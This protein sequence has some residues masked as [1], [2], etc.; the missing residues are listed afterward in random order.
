MKKNLLLAINHCIRTSL[1]SRL[2][3]VFASC[4]LPLCSVTSIQAA[5]E[6]EK[7][8]N[9]PSDSQNLVNRLDEYEEREKL[10]LEKVLDMKRGEAL[11]ILNKKRG[12]V[13]TILKK[14]LKSY[15]KN[16][17]FDQALAIRTEIS[18][19]EA[20]S[21]PTP[22]RLY[23]T[24]KTYEENGKIVPDSNVADNFLIDVDDRKGRVLLDFSHP[25]LEQM[26]ESSS[27]IQLEL[28]I[29]DVV[30]SNTASPIVIKYKN[31][32]IGQQIGAK[33]GETLKIELQAWK[34]IR[35][36]KSISLSI[37]NAGVDAFGVIT[38]LKGDFV[39]LIF[40]GK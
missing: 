22:K 20:L 13:L 2:A 6:A 4:I 27:R 7:V 37:E 38:N 24:K 30:G 28:K 8:A 29:S 12:E 35:S 1:S 11:T 40:N 26:I 19:I 33:Y 39:S 31:K 25:I 36:G 10:K 9:L 17:Q 14:H 34:I 23:A 15:T 21:K 3:I 5:G 16:G 18:R 32:I